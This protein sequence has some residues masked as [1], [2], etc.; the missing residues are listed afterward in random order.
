MVIQARGGEHLPSLGGDA[1]IGQ[2]RQPVDVVDI[3]R[4]A[5]QHVDLAGLVGNGA[6]GSVGD[7]LIVDFVE[8][9]PVLQPIV[10]IA[11]EM[12]EGALLPLL[13][14]ERACSDRRVVRRI[15]A[16]IAALIDVLGD[17][18]G[19]GDLHRQEEGTER[20]FENDLD[21]QLVDLL[22]FLDLRIGDQAPA[23]M[24]LAQEFIE[25]E[26][27]IVGAERL[28]IMPFD[29]ALQVERIGLGVLG[30]LP[31][32]GE[33]GQRVEFL[34]VAQQRFVNIAG[35]HLRRPVLIEAKHE[36]WRFGLNHDMDG[37]A[38]FGRLRRGWA[39]G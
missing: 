27:D 14:F 11:Y 17:H 26:D 33:R 23:G 34:V 29:A 39:A 37:A 9:R 7:H 5:G 38:L 22:D 31:A 16:E 10:F 35:H 1:G 13:E 2:F 30:N 8:I 18:R 28:A 12:D 24:D 6:G 25:G 3:D 20:L 36:E 4:T 19:R 15:G 21:R 32:L